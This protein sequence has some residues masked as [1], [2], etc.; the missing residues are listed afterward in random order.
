MGKLILIMN[1][2]NSYLWLFL[3]WSDETPKITQ[4][5]YFYFVKDSRAMHGWTP[6]MNVTRQ[7]GN[8]TLA[9]YWLWEK[10]EK[11]RWAPLRYIYLFEWLISVPQYDLFVS[12]TYFHMKTTHHAFNLLFGGVK[13]MFFRC[14]Y[15]LNIS[16]Y[17]IK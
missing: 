3:R 10:K 12:V 11:K 7:N 13:F 9:Y 8:S 1:V 14:Y 6:W 16:W 2:I 4:H 17:I 5:C 15:S